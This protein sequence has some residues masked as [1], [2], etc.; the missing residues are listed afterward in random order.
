MFITGFGALLLSAIQAG[1]ASH[2]PIPLHATWQIGLT[3]REF[4]VSAEIL[5]TN[6]SVSSGVVEIHVIAFN[7]ISFAMGTG[8]GSRRGYSSPEYWIFT[9]DVVEDQI[10]RYG[11]SPGPPLGTRSYFAVWQKSPDS[12]CWRAYNLGWGMLEKCFRHPDAAKG[13]GVQVSSRSTSSSNTIPGDYV[14]ARVMLWSGSNQVWRSWQDYYINPKCLSD[15][16]YWI[17]Q[18]SWTSY[19]TGPPGAGPNDC[20]ISPAWRVPILV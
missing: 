10:I 6:P 3:G 15:G 9:Y 5:S 2:Y 4:G 20:N 17:D 11:S 14:N 19:L 1:L 16:G 18:R 8:I 13:A 12:T 7:P